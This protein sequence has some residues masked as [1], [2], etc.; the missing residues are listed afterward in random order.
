MHGSLSDN[1]V[2]I[3]VAQ[4]M[5]DCFENF[6][7][8]NNSSC[9][10]PLENAC[11]VYSEET[12]KANLLNNFFR[13]QTVLND[14]DAVLPDMVPYA[15]QS[16]LQ[17]LIFSPDEVKEILIALQARKATGPEEISNRV[18][19]ELS[20]ELSSPLCSFFNYSLSFG[21]VPDIFKEA[22]VCPIP[23]GGDLSII[24]ITDQF[25]C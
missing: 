9:I 20:S 21:E 14:K 17:S 4:A 8:S 24:S 19:K 22:H 25:P 10:P 7:F 15:V 5:M 11:V 18:L 12:D 16:Q 3:S 23:K 1:K 6:H 2:W 13:D